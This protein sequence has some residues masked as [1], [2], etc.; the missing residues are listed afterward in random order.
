MVDVSVTL[1][2]ETGITVMVVPDAQ[3]V[4]VT[5]MTWGWTVISLTR[6]LAS[7]SRTVVV[8]PAYSVV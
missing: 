8:P 4:E 5:V 6:S 7:R 3:V 2:I 1:M